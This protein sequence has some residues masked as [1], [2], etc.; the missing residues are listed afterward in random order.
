MSTINLITS[1]PGPKSL[2]M[3]E[4][5]KNALPAGLAKSTE[6]AVAKAEGGI[7]WDVDGNTLLDFA[8]GIGMINVGHRNEKVVNAV[9]EQLD[10]YIHTCSLVTTF[11]PY[12]ELAEMLNR[13][14]PGEFAKKTLLCNSGTEAVENAVMLARYFTK[15]PGIICFEGAYHGRSLLTLSLTSKYGLFK[16]GFGSFAGDIYRIHAPNMYRVPDGMS[17]EQYLDWCIKNLENSLITQVDPEACAAIIIEPVI[18]EGGFIQ[19]PAPFMQKIRELCTKHGIVMIAD[20]IQAGSGRTGKLFAIEHTGV[21]ADIMCVA[22]SMGAGFPISAVVGKAEIM[23]CTHLGGVGGTYGGSPVAAVA[24]IE[25]LKILSSP[26]FLQR[27]THVGELI[28]Q[29]MNKWKEQYKLVG[30]VRGPGAMKLVEFVKDKT[31]KEPFMDLA[32][33]VLKDAVSKGLLLIRAGLY[34]NCI[35]LLP[36]IVMPDEQLQEGLDVLEAAVANAHKKR[37]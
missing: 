31:T 34:S 1:I 8:G 14:A 24:A 27:A 10:K 7:V 21:A 16:K 18:G 37:E 28:Q 33:E 5:R 6:V 9:K 23:D 19:I 11:E 26:E 29:R 30:D 3:L 25:T 32:M 22:K 36:P 17:D 20:E 13:F 2:A 4:R 35:R 12:I 15:R